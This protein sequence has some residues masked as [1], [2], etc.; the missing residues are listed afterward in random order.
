V[1]S[2][3]I[4][5]EG[6]GSTIARGDEAP[7]FRLLA[8]NGTGDLTLQETTVRGGVFYYG[9]GGGVAN[10][11]GTLTV[12]NSTITGNIA[13]DGGGG[14][15]NFG[16]LAV[17]HSTISGNAAALVGS[18]GGGV[19]NLGGT[20]AV[21]HSTISGNT[22]FSY[23]SGGVWN[24][25][26]LT[27]ARTLVTGNT[28][29]IG[30][31]IENFG[32]GTVVA[33]DYNLFGVDGTAGVSGFSP[34][35]TDVVPSAGV[36]L[37]DILDPTLALHG[38]STQI[39]ALVPGSPAIDAGGQVCLDADGDPLLTDQRGR[40]RP[41]DGDG[42]RTAAC[43]I[44]AFE[45]FPLVNDFVTLD[46]ALETTSDPTPVPG[47]PA[48]TFTITATFMNTRE[49]P[50]RVPF[51]E[52]TALSGGN[53]LL[54]ADAGPGGVG[55]TLTPDVGDRVLSPGETVMVGFVIGLQVRAPFTFV[56]EL[57]GEPLR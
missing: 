54:N 1:V 15:R 5:I 31:E 32:D 40:P 14:V 34:G 10:V 46:P 18:G 44:G 23:G 16:T 12:T 21:T 43:D 27:L 30:P 33:A 13:Y 53:L 36:R 26:T 50:L 56:V 37:V 25:S 11:G 41:V 9:D 28:G 8:V 29:P 48:G 20:L 4:T 57:F 19:A 7:E 45:F 52:V 35:P 6:Q 47:G 55:A 38:G 2:S 42:D 39:H 51:F 17:T 22:A 24:R 3:V 49:T